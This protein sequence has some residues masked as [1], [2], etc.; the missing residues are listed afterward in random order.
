MRRDRPGHLRTTDGGAAIDRYTVSI[1]PTAGGAAQTKEVTNP[2]ALTATFTGLTNG[3][4]YTASVAAH[5][6]N[7]DGA[8]GRRR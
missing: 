4:E 8:A 2:N 6:T 7:G 5:N 1:R 3:T